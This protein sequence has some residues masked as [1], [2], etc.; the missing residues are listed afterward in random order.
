MICRLGFVV[1][2]YI[3]PM[4]Y[5][6]YSFTLSIIHFAILT[7]KQKQALSQ[8]LSVQFGTVIHFVQNKIAVGGRG[9]RQSVSGGAAVVSWG[10]VEEWVTGFRLVFVW[11][12]YYSSH[13]T[14]SFLDCLYKSHLKPNN[15]LSWT[16]LLPI[17]INNF[18]III[19]S[20]PFQFS[21]PWW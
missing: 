18:C 14:F 11:V 16:S 19:I 2:I 1:Q 4:S 17:F 6:S 10:E 15:L 8:V 3:N 7:E 21:I 5:V 12:V 13:F 20:I 9:K